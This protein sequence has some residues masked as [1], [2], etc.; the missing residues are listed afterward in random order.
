MKNI[1]MCRRF[2]SKD[3]RLYAL[4]EDITVNPGDILTVDYYLP[5]GSTATAYAVS[6]SYKV[7]DEEAA[8]IADL[9][10][11]RSGTL[12]NL[13]KVRSVYSGET[14]CQYPETPE[15]P[16]GPELLEEDDAEEEEEG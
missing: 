4:P 5:T 13:K 15:E 16:D 11:F 12:D 14:V 10:H 8:M 1:V 2:E 7:T 9:F 3:S 6:K